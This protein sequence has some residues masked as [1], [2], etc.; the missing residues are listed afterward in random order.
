MWNIQK[1]HGNVLLSMKVWL[2]FLTGG[3]TEG[4]N[5]P[6]PAHFLVHI[7]NCKAHDKGQSGTNNHHIAQSCEC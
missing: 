3:L 2:N 6:N 7:M 5:W 1:V 4:K